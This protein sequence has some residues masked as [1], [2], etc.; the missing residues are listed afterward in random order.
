MKPILLAT[1]GSPTAERATETA[2]EHAKAFGAPLLIVSVW[3]VRYEPIGIAY[4]PVMP[5]IDHVGHTQA[6]KIVEKAATKAHAAGVQTDT[7]IRRG[8]PVYQICAI[9]DEHDPMLIVLG[10]HGWGSFKRVLFGSVSTGVL[11]HAKQPVLVVRETDRLA[12]AK[13]ADTEKKLKV[14]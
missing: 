10:S 5:D 1:D 4:G 11:H 12:K 2:I 8:T 14:V 13:A 7:I 6:Q 3:D 9:A